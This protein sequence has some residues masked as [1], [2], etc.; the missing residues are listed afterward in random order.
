[1]T[2]VAYFLI[3]FHA[4]VILKSLSVGICGS[5]V[6]VSDLLHIDLPHVLPDVILSPTR[7]T[8]YWCHG[9]I[10]DFIVKSPMI[11]GHETSA[12]VHEVGEGVR[13]LKAG[14]IVAIEP[15]ICCD[16]QSTA[17]NDAMLLTH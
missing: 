2:F 4:E 8:K 13:D 1:M 16:V 12:E 15:G 17:H 9:G 7:D 14:D 5:D 6:H 10:G 3:I 11:L